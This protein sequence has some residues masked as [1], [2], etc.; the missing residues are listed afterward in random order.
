MDKI[1]HLWRNQALSSKLATLFSL[2]LIALVIALTSLSIY[3]ERISFRREL[4]EQATLLLETLPLT[5]RDQLYRLELDEMMD[6]ARV[7]SQSEDVVLFIVY[8]QQGAV[9]VDASQ[10]DPVFSQQVDPLGEALIDAAQE[11]VY[12]DWQEDRLVA[13]RAISLGNQPIGAVAIGLSTAPLQQKIVALARQSALVVLVTL[14]VGIGAASLIARQ[15]TGPLSILTDVA[16]QMTS[17]DLSSRVKLQSEDEIGQ[18]GDAF[19]QMAAAIERRETEL[20]ELAEELERK[21][22]ARTAELRAQN[23]ELIVAR[24]QAEAASR[25]KSTFLATMSHEIRTPM[26]GVI[27]MTSLLLDTELTAEQQEFV[28]T[29]RTSGETLLDIINDILDFSKIEA[30]R[31]DLERQ[32]FGLRECVKE[33]VDLL[34]NE[35]AEKDL[36][37]TY[38]VDDEVPA[39]IWGDVTRLRQIL[40]NLLNN[41]IKFTEDGEVVV[42]VRRG[43]AIVSPDHST[44]LPPPYFLLHFSVRDTGIGIPAERQDRLFQSFSQV[45]TSTT[46]KYGGTGLGLAISNRLVEMMKGKMWVESEVDVGSTFHFTIQAKEAEPSEAPAAEV[47]TVQRPQFDSEMA[48]RLPLRILLVEDNLVNQKLAA[49][50]LERLGYQADLAANG[51]EALDA[52]RR[53]AYDVVL[54]DVLMPEM[55]GMEATRRIR[56]EIAQEQQ[57]H[58]IA[59]TANAMKEDREKYLSAGMDD[60]L[61]KPIRVQELVEAL[62]ECA[63]SA[64]AA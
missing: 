18:L 6:I 11:Q 61:S 12:L 23:E 5:M 47:G 54:M 45:D 25:A 9:L 33:A 51:L 28:D 31:M 52:L 16:A 36:N 35:A 37:L 15:I 27:G 19:N 40:I 14:L 62:N 50:L 57:P 48:E 60:Y 32:P 55:D 24:R 43:E 13:G 58:I 34:A 22:E 20:R 8:D 53:Q 56:R 3:R 17:G 59:V 39:A 49:R 1:R 44:L 29:I 2:L 7:V 10:P 64:N 63:P 21:V 30:G 38:K 42:R 4:E 26:N 41:A 46:R